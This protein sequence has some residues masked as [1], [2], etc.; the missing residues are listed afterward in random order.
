[1]VHKPQFLYHGW[2][3]DELE[4]RFHTTL[5]P[6]KWKK[7]MIFASEL[8]KCKFYWWRHNI[9]CSIEIIS[10]IRDWFSAKFWYVVAETILFRICIHCFSLFWR[11]HSENLD[12]KRHD[13][14]FC[15]YVLSL[16]EFNFFSNHELT[17]QCIG[18]CNSLIFAPFAL[19][20][21]YVIADKIISRK[22]SI[23]IPIRYSHQGEIFVWNLNLDMDSD[24][25]LVSRVMVYGK[26]FGRMDN[27]SVL[28]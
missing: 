28:Q 16:W 12:L 27:A 17:W 24:H 18:S 10:L 9:L 23:F 11:H 14:I 1:M 20:F 26:D 3:E 5:T 4:I 19:R 15:V 6:G 8:K 21:W 25:F 22:C 13:K 2:Q 7:V